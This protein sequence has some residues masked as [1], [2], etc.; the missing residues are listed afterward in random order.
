MNKNLKKLGKIKAIEL[1]LANLQKYDFDSKLAELS[2]IMKKKI[3]E[4]AE[5][6]PEL[7]NYKE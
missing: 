4:N 3:I 5:T 1:I 7:D 6:L 2:N